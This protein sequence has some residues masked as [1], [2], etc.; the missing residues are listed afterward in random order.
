MSLSCAPVALAEGKRRENK[1]G[2]EETRLLPK[3]GQPMNH[4]QPPSDTGTAPRRTIIAQRGRAGCFMCE[5]LTAQ[6][7]PRHQPPQL[8]GTAYA[9]PCSL[10]GSQPVVSLPHY[11]GQWGKGKGWIVIVV[12]PTTHPALDCCLSM[13]TASRYLGPATASVFTGIRAIT[14]TAPGVAAPARPAGAPRIH[15]TIT[16]IKGCLS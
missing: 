16:H 9:F 6:P 12:T 10:V 14:L 1:A 7:G 5:C 11:T 15:D 13:I 8:L 3:A 4:S 2:Y